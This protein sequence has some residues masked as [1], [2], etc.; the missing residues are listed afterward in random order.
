MAPCNHSFSAAM[1]SAKTISYALMHLT[2]AIAVAYA[3]T[4]DWRQALAIGVVEPFVQTF[5]FTLHDRYWRKR[6]QQSAASDWAK[7][8]A[9]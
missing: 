2:V 6:E 1:V 7:Q 8:A 4:L 5:A 3:L 9:S